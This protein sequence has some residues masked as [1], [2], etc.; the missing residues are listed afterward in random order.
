MEGP[1]T[2]SGGLQR[3]EFSQK[4]Y[5]VI[6]FCMLILA[7]WG[8]RRLTGATSQ[9]FSRGYMVRDGITVIRF[10]DLS[11]LIQWITFSITHINK[12]SL[13]SSVI[14]LEAWKCYENCSSFER[15]IKG[16]GRPPLGE[17]VGLGT[18]TE[19][20]AKPCRFLREKS[21]ICGKSHTGSL[22]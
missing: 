19:C 12:S 6:C 16:P 7:Q 20:T 4:S 11:V 5:D 17:D 15:M 10:K 21:V 8:W 3:H 1:E 18:W 13:Q 22:S 14:F 2:L 9:G